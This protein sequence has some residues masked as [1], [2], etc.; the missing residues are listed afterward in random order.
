[1]VLGYTQNFLQEPLDLVG[2]AEM[3]PSSKAQ[4]EISN[5]QGLHQAHPKAIHS[6]ATLLFPLSAPTRIPPDLEPQVS[7][8]SAGTSPQLMPA[9]P[10]EPLFP[11]SGSGSNVTS[12]PTKRVKVLS[13]VRPFVIPWAVA[14]QAPP[15]MEFSRQEC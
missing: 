4:L 2:E 13:H 8:S 15:S 1:M 9:P 14:H 10:P 3:Y 5:F 11:L 7:L 12:H 6:P